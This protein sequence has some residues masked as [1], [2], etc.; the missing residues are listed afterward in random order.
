MSMAEQK[1]EWLK[2]N[3]KATLSEAWDAGYFTCTDNW[4]K[5]RK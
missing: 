5:S 4:C 2:K 1:T 3:P